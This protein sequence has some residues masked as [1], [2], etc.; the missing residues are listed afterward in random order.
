MKEGSP[1]RIVLIEDNPGDVLLIRLV[2][3]EQSFKYQLEVLGDGEQALRF[4]R[5]YC[6][7]VCG[8]SPCVL[9]LDLHLPK[10][11][12][13]RSFESTPK[14]ASIVARS[15]GRPHGN[16]ISRRRSPYPKFWRASVSAKADRS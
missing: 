12:G 13:F 8:H 2:L 9:V 1:A 5:E 3:D 16:Y 4:V 10:Y 6:G 15:R 11:N 14:R 7:S